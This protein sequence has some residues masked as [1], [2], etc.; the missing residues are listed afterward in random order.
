MSARAELG[1]LEASGLIEIAALQPELEYLFRHA[2]VQEAAYSSL[3]KQDRRLLHRGAAETI[4]ALHPDRERELA[5]V[6]A[7]H[8]EH[9]GDATRAAE[10][11]ALAG[12]HALERFANR[13]AI[14]FFAR[15]DM[16]ADEAEID[17]RLRAAIGGA[18]AGWTY[19]SPG[20][21]IERLERALAA[22]GRAD[23]RLVAQAYFWVAFLRRQGGE[24][25]E[26]SPALQEALDR[27]KQ[28]GSA[29]NDPAA[30]A[31][32]KAL[33][34]SYTAFI[35]DLRQGAREM[36]EALEEIADQRD[37]LSTAMISNFLAITYARLGEFDAAEAAIAES[38]LHAVAVDDIA[39]VD[40]D[41]A[42]SALDLERGEVDKA[43]ILA[44]E[45]AARSEDLGAWAC[46]VV[47]NVMFGAA[48]LAREDAPAAK[49]PL[50]RSNELSRVTNMAP[51]RTLAQGFLGSVRAQ[52][53]DLPGGIEAW[54]QALAGARAMN[55]RYGEA[56]TLW[57]RARAYARLPEAN[58]PAAL[59]DLDRAIELFERMETRPSLARALRDRAQALR[60]LSHGAQAEGDERRSLE[61]GRE[62]GL[63]DL[64]AA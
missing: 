43:S 52:L 44:S 23:Q 54:D 40:L 63:K 14:A 2:L 39:H 47:S 8:F 60:E 58:W 15:V 33:M 1:S 37:R 51:M 32:P 20:S 59:A 35:G 48:S 42:E 34:G 56:Q 3:L 31:L 49:E 11:Y 57:G 13:E 29:L 22:A 21:D 62:L 38:R 17:L 25:P 16:L 7:M 61:L 27:A 18:K 26:T 9:A 28:V 36:R 45:C 53:G 12:D 50:E 64:G 41:I 4:L 30:A 10:Y 46:V 24:V 55:D 6:I 5:G 19:T